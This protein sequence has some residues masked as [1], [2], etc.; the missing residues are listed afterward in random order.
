M[1]AQYVSAKKLIN[2]IAFPLVEGAETFV[3]IT[4]PRRATGF[5]Q[6]PLQ[7]VLW[8]SSLRFMCKWGFGLECDKLYLHAHKCLHGGVLWNRDNFIVVR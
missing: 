3:F 6:P 2:S 1:C 8:A 4:V 5:T 7:W